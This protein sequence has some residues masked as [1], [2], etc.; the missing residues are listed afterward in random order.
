[1]TVHP[2]AVPEN[3]KID[4]EGVL[5]SEARLAVSVSPEAIV[6]PSWNT[7]SGS[8]SAGPAGLSLASPAELA[9]RS[10]HRSREEPSRPTAR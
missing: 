2:P 3:D 9:C 10:M 1:M 5:R 4:C 6:L 7:P 8:H